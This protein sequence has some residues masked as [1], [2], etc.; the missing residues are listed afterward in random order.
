MNSAEDANF[1]VWNGFYYFKNVV[2]CYRVHRKSELDHW[3][4][5]LIDFVE[6]RLQGFSNVGEL[7]VKGVSVIRYIHLGSLVRL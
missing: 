3:F 6:V 1:D 4:F 7:I 5:T 2:F